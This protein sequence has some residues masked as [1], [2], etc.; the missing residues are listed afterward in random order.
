[1]LKERRTYE[2]MSPEDVGIQRT[3]LVLGKHSGRHALRQRI[4]E[5]GYHLDD[6]QLQRVFEGFKGLADRKKEVYDADIEALAE[7]EIHQGP[8]LW[9]LEAFTCNAGSGTIPH[10]AV[11]LWHRDGQIHRDATVGDGPV[12]A[13]FKAIERITGL[14]VN[15]KDYS[16]RSVTVGE[17]AQGEAQV[18]AEYDGRIVRGR[19]V[20]TDIIEASALAFLQVINRISL[21]QK[22]PR[23]N[24]QTEEVTVV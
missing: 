5:L 22:M 17:D 18:E 12:D 24:P 15:L 14:E 10:A 9:T 13:V 11:C 4:R 1:M 23:M 2:I 8:A 20:S 19:A 16:V 7:A 21:R 3:E 6:A